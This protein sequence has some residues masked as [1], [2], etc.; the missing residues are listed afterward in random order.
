LGQLE[1]ENL[2]LFL[3][4]LRIFRTGCQWLMFIILATWEAEIG[5]WVNSLQD[6]IS[7]IT[8]AK[9]T[10]GVVQMVQRACFASMKLNSNPSSTKKTQKNIINNQITM[11]RM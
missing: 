9:W 8:K 3:Q 10:G 2:E 11:L 5:T 6:S 1:N 7:K 4:K